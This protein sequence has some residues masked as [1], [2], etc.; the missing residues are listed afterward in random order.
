MCFFF[1]IIRIPS[2]SVSIKATAVS[3]SIIHLFT[4]IIAIISNSLMLYIIW[5]F[6]CLQTP[7][8]LLLTSLCVTD[9]ITGTVVQPLSI[10]RRIIEAWG[11]HNCGIRAVCAYHAFLCISMSIQNVAIISMDR[12]IAIKM[13]FKYPHIATLERY[14]KIIIFT[15]LFWAAFMSMP[16][17]KVL[18]ASMFFVAI[19]ASTSANILIVLIAYAQIFKVVLKHRR[20]IDEQNSHRAREPDARRTNTKTIAIVIL[21]MLICYLPLLPLLIVRSVAGDSV[22]VIFILDTWVDVFIYANSSV[23]PIIYWYRSKEVKRA[24]HIV[25][26]RW[27]ILPKRKTPSCSIRTAAVPVYSVSQHLQRAPQTI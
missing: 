24:I 26:Q 17:L 4:A 16:F 21:V 8:N 13:P 27:N 9:L 15:W 10:A 11:T 5:K 2:P 1:E 19:T 20:Q 7:S 18:N 6:K 23:N 22:N 25:L 14:F 3:T 12:W